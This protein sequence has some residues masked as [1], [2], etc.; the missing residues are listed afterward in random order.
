MQLASLSKAG[1][2][3]DIHLRNNE[4][5]IL[6]ALNRHERRADTTPLIRFPMK[7]NNGRIKTD[8]MKINWL[9][10]C[11]LGI[12]NPDRVNNL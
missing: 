10:V 2:F 6:G 3:G 4:K 12:D 5:K 8:Q 9:D 7:E 1:E 11:L